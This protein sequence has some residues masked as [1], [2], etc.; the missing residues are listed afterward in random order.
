VSRAA[1]LV[2][3]LA[4]VLVPGDARGHGVLHEVERGRAVAV[5]ARLAGGAALA[6]AQYEVYSPADA[7]IPHQKGRTDRSGWLA[8]VPDVPGRWRVKIVDGT[9]HGLDV[10]VDAAPAPSVPAPPAATSVPAPPA[11]ASV[12]TAA[13]V[14][15]PLL[16]L[17]AIAAVFGLLLA[18][19]RRKGAR[20]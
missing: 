17:A 14:L 7:G 16:G 15:R 19:Y 9:G 8:F 3:A 2:A 6:Y 13:F 18:V 1:A 10:E 11:A 4:A 12:S 5:R 20:P